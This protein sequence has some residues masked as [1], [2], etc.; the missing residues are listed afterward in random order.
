MAD[1]FTQCAESPIAQTMFK[2]AIR[3][4]LEVEGGY[5]NH[6]ADRG[7]ATQ[8]GISLRF[9]SS[10]PTD[11]GDITGDGHV[12]INDIQ[13][14]SEADAIAFYR[15]YFF[16]HYRL[17]NILCQR[18]LTKAL[19][20]HINMRGR[21]AGRVVQRACRA[22]GYPLV[23]DG[24]LGSKSFQAINTVGQNILVPAICSEAAGVYRLIVER[25]AD[26]AVFLKGWLN[27][28]YSDA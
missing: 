10:L 7:G 4:V 8:Y 23:E 18:T 24:I 15:K 16:E 11:L 28:A 1:S 12:D 26:Q 19:G 5:S 13:N 3:S 6:S 9:L 2:N 22:C 17:Y 14:L 27:R 25:D 21:V 20:L